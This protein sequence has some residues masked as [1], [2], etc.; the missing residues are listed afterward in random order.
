MN[1]VMHTTGITIVPEGEPIYNENGY[2]LSIED[3]AAGPFVKISDNTV[4]RNE[5]A[6]AIE[7]EAW[8]MIKQAMEMLIK[9]C[10]KLN[11]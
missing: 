9:S 1:Y 6:V 11:F 8:P 10:E 5:N 3:E 4:D 2:R 7:I